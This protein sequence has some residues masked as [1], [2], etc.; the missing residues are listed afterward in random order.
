MFTVTA[1]FWL[2]ATFN[3]A[4]GFQICKQ[5]PGVEERVF[6]N[7]L[8]IGLINAIKDKFGEIV[9]PG[10]KFDSSDKVVTGKN[11]R[12]IFVW[13][14]ERRWVIA[15]EHGGLGYNNPVF[16]FEV[17]ADGLEA[18]LVAEAIVLRTDS[19]CGTAVRLIE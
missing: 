5:P 10:E 1:I 6:P 18:K 12:A 16:A 14:R 9:A 19:L 15:T 13:M 17:S 7:D 4:S 8:P 2:A 3:V 11:R